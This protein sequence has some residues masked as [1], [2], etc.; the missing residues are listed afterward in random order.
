LIKAVKYTHQIWVQYWG[1][2][3]CCLWICLCKEMD[4]DSSSGIN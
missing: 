2:R 4:W 1:T 3:S